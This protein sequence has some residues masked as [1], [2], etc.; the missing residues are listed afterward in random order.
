M[1]SK[2]IF[3][4]IFL[5][6][7]FAISQWSDDPN[8]NT[9]VNDTIGSQVLPKVATNSLGETYIS[10]FSDP[11]NLNYNV[12]LQKLDK[13]G[14]KIWDE[15]GL[16]ISDHE[17][18]SW[19]T[20][21]DMIL[22][23]EENVILANQDKRTGD[24]NVFA[25]KISPDG[26]FL[27]GS[28]GVQLSNTVGFDPSPQVV[29][30][31]NNDLVFMWA[32]DPV[33]TTANSPIYIKRVSPGGNILW[34]SM[35][36]DTTY[37]YMLP[38][39]LHTDNDD[40][41]ISWMTKTNLPDTIIGE[42]H[43][44]HVFAQ[45][46][47]MDGNPVWADKI[48]IDSGNIMLYLSL[49]STPFLCSDGDGGAYVMW[50]SFFVDQQDGNPTT[51]IN[52]IDQNAN[53]WA[54][55]GYSVSMNSGNYQASAVMEYFKDEEK[56]MVSWQEYH[57]QSGTDCFGVYG[58]LFSANGQYLWD[59][60]GLEIVP[61]ICAVD[62]LIYSV[63]MERSINNNVIV[64]YGKEYFSIDGSDTTFQTELYATSIGLDG[65]KLWTPEFVPLS[66]TFSTKN[67]FDLGNRVG[68][69][70]VSVWSDNRENPEDDF[71]FGIYTQN[72]SVDG[73]IGPLGINQQNTN[74]EQLFDI[75]PN[76][77]DYFVQVNYTIES[78]CEVEIILLD[79]H[80]KIIKEL[81]S[82]SQLSGTYH[83]II[84]LSELE[85]GVYLLQFNGNKTTAC[86]KL[87]KH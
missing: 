63:E 41:I 78:A 44:M 67:Y 8:V 84:D 17:T 64:T 25:Y 7:V 20:D 28:D 52:R 85:N 29:V 58:Q 40:F 30:A 54:P 45:K 10:W 37:D 46:I 76:P 43:Y 21:Y 81:F 35:L 2:T 57:Y 32:E 15:G 59:E 79:I 74:A 82:G 83:Q 86:K 56:L 66:L 87:I 16:L 33:D 73:Q 80:G 13:N 14:M 53:L 26:D 34:E 62:T 36:S 69:Q 27:W 70:L 19:V 4:L 1:K 71:D 68:D 31:D 9:K 61:L 75:F 50:Q 39:I 22:D 55:N 72:I 12:Y 24:R 47:D 51:Y 65:Q 18:M 48:Q 11:G 6:P 49:Y 42:E 3:L 38:Q 5:L 23:N 77:V 60:N